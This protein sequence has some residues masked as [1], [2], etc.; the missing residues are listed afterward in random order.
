MGVISTLRTRI[1]ELE[2]R[3]HYSHDGELIESG[4]LVSTFEELALDVEY[5]I[6]WEPKQIDETQGNKTPAKKRK[7]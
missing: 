4:E 7:L 5:I 3:G 2:F 6:F 1:I